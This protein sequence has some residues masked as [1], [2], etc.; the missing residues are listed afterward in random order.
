MTQLAFL[1]YLELDNSADERAIRRA[2]AGKLKLID[3][4]ADAAG[5]QA[6]REAYEVS[7]QWV[8]W[9]QQQA[10]Q[11]AAM[12]D[13]ETA[14]EAT[15][16]ASEPPVAVQIPVPEP[17]TNPALAPIGHVLLDATPPE[18]A[19]QAVFNE[20]AA[21]LAASSSAAGWASDTVHRDKLL[22]CLDDPRL[23]S[24]AARDIFEWYVAELLANG[25][26]P[27]QEA[28]LVAATRVFAWHDDPRRLLR[29][30]WVGDILNRAIIERTA[31]DQQAESTKKEQRDLIARLRDPVPPSHGELIAKMS[32][33]ERTFSQFP[34][35]FQLITNM[36]NLQ[37][38]RELDRQV[39]SWRRRL[40]FQ[41]TRVAM[42]SVTSD[43][44]SPRWVIVLLI[45][46]TIRLGSSLTSS[47]SPP[48]VASTS[49]MPNVLLQ[50]SDAPDGTRN[51]NASGAFPYASSVADTF[52]A[53]NL[54][55]PESAPV[56]PSKAQLAALANGKPNLEKCDEIA[57]LTQVFKVGTAQALTRVTPAFERQVINCANA[58]LW[59]RSVF[60]D[61]AIQEAIH[62]EDQR[63]AAAIRS[64]Q[65]EMEN[66]VKVSPRVEKP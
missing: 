19:A 23:L 49:G 18:A 57:R 3:Q 5:F 17:E 2:Y 26:R 59:P 42:P 54:K 16:A 66:L 48:P 8:R 47:N 29:F 15:P 1:D 11:Q 40:S 45:V 21:E 31:F 51:T 13:E 24:I 25:W 56:P 37:Q 62:H 50:Q 43:G 38:W 44:F 34:A 39:P 4:E 55:T 53:N 28:L 14:A 36:E 58:S 32:M 20:L 63:S 33:I 27:G 35:W 22:R 46:I 60:Q 64:M 9:Q 6:L 52:R 65:R 7:L 10:A 61:P 12:S 41:K 30:G